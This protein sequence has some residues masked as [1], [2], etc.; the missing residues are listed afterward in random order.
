MRGGWK[1]IMIIV[2]IIII[3]NTQMTAVALGP[4][5]SHPDNRMEP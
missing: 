5:T 2:I 4:W 3:I 1:M